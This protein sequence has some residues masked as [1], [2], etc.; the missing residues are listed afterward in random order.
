MGF[1]VAWW[2]YPIA[3]WQYI[4]GQLPD[5]YMYPVA[6]DPGPLSHFG[7]LSN[8]L[9]DFWWEE[10]STPPPAGAEPFVKSFHCSDLDPQVW[11]PVCDSI[12]A[13]RGGGALDTWSHSH[14]GNAKE[15]NFSFPLFIFFY[16]KVD[17]INFGNP[18][19]VEE[20]HV[21]NIF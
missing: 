14:N 4:Y 1:L 5:G 13:G 10:M 9:P 17:V 15:I 20:V 11:D 19:K 16:A 6:C 8:F 12:Q 7:Q 18:S 3:R 21:D 2:L